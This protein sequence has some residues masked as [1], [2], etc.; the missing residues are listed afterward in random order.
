MG[1]HRRQRPPES[2]ND[3]ND[4]SEDSDDAF[5]ALSSGGKRDALSSKTGDDSKTLSST[6]RKRHY[7][8]ETSQRKAKMEALLQEL[9]H[10]SSTAP[11]KVTGT[12]LKGSY[13]QPGEEHVTTNLFVGNLATNISEQDL[14]NIF[15]QF[16]EAQIVFQLGL[17]CCFWGTRLRRI[18]A[19]V[20]HSSC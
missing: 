16:G 20:S 7:G 9:Q 6:S 4:D 2:F 10:T 17:L 14:G 5:S 11:T 1:P 3:N 15:G 12:H 8:A 19:V 18:P 13:V